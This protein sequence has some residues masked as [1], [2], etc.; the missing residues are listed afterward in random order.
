MV[1]CCDNAVCSFIWKWFTPIVRFWG[2][3][4]AVVIWIICVRH[5]EDSVDFFSIYLVVVA[6]F[7]TILEAVFLFEPCITRC[8]TPDG[9]CGKFWLCICWFDNWKRAIVYVG[10]SIGCYLDKSEP[11]TITAG[12]MLDV[13][14]ILYI[15]RTYRV[16]S[17]NEAR[18]HQPDQTIKSGKTYG[19]FENDDLKSKEM[20]G[21]AEDQP[22]IMAHDEDIE[23]G[24][25]PFG[26]YGND[27]DADPR[28]DAGLPSR[29][30]P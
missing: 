20:P 3:I 21:V 1:N 23:K 5:F 2:V 6:S 25:N 28:G 10:L 8:C 11:L 17:H 15:L 27:D 14:A 7:T 16:L 13:L 29:Y 30:P 18:E 26:G 12:V 4:S 22:A 24:G 19:R 9:C